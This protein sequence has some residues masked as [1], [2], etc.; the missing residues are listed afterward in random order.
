MSRFPRFLADSPSSRN[1]QYR[2]SDVMT[3]IMGM[4]G[5]VYRKDFSPNTV[6]IAKAMKSFNPDTTW[7][8]DEDQQE[9]SAAEQKAT[10]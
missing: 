4:D 2:S 3:F 6:T 5:V 7:R 9:E 1:R 10:N 8:K